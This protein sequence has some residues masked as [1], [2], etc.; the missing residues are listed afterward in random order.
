M[1]VLIRRRWPIAAVAFGPEIVPA[2]RTHHT[3][4]LLPIRRRSSGPALSNANSVHVHDLDRVI[5]T[6]DLVAR[7]LF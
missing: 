4:A 1:S 2:V 7:G 6:K 3:Y 5:I